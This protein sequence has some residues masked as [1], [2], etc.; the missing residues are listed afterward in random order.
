MKKTLSLILAIILTFSMGTLAFAGEAV[1]LTKDEAKAKAVEHVNYD[2]EV[3]LATY[4]LS[5]TFNDDIQGTVEVYNVTSTLVLKTGR[6]VTYYTVVDKYSGKIYYQKATIVDLPSLFDLT[7][8]TA[9]SLAI[10]VL[11]LNESNTSVL[12]TNG[13][14]GKAPFSFVLVEGFS[15]KYECTVKKG[16][17]LS[18]VVDDIKVS[19]Y[20]VESSDDISASNIIQKIVLIFKVLIAKLNPANLLDKISANDLLK[21]FQFLAG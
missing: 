4:A 6:T 16:D 1:A 10:E 2:S 17:L 9:L 19:K 12:S 7:E 3:S 18:V 21:V 20:T 15:Q 13:T 8:E 5:G 11:G 14:E